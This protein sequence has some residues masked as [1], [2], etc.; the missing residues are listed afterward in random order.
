MGRCVVWAQWEERSDPLARRIGTKSVRASRSLNR[1][2]CSVR[3][4]ER[5][6]SWPQRNRRLLAKRRGPRPWPADR[7][8]RP[9]PASTSDKAASPPVPGTSGRYPGRSVP[10]SP[11]NKAGDDTVFDRRR[12]GPFDPCARQRAAHPCHLDPGREKGR[13]VS[14]EGDRAQESIRLWSEWI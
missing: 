11:W 1:G 3:G 8:N 6:P 13:A 14:P 9:T 2:L 5:S 12:H 10:G 4:R 7:H